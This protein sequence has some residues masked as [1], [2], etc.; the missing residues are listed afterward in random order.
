VW[1]ESTEGK[2][3]CFWFALPLRKEADPD[4]AQVP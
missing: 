1:V 2:G 4:R 3:S